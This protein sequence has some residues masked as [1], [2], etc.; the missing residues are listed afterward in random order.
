MLLVAQEMALE[1]LATDLAAILEE[2][3]PLP[4][5]S[6]IDINLRIEALRRHRSDGKGSRNFSRID[7]VAESYRRM[8]NIEPSNGT[9]DPN[10][11]GILLVQAH[12]ERIAFA[13]PGNNAQ[14][15]LANGKYAMAGHK[16]DLAYEPWL[17]VAH[18]DARQ[19]MGKI[20][21]ASPLNPQDL[22][23]MLKEQEVITWDTK[24]GGLI[25]TLDLRIGNIVL[26]SKTLPDPDESHL[27]EAIVML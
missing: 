7:K 5:E 13:R 21:L 4:R 15:Q 17:A 18:V 1:D 9:F 2:R 19:G 22:Q 27:I 26:Q 10:D 20:F 14:F 11:T 6:G 23:P 25:A 24:K 8:L 3:D 12:P 16:D